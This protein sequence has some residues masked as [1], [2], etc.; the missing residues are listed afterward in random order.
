MSSSKSALKGLLVTA[1]LSTLTTATAI[2]A[3]LVRRKDFEPGD[4][5]NRTMCFCTNS[6]NFIQTNEDPFTLSHYTP[7][8]QVAFVYN[9]DY[10][11]HREIHVIQVNITPREH[12]LDHHFSL[13]V[14]DNCPTMPTYWPGHHSSRCLQHLAKPQHKTY[15]N[16]YY[17]GDLPYGITI[18]DWKFCYG[19]R[20]DVFGNPK[21]RDFFEF[22][23]DRRKLPR[24]R[25]WIA[26]NEEVAQV[27]GEV[28]KSAYGMEMFRDQ[29]GE[30]FSR[31]DYFH[32]SLLFSSDVRQV[33]GM[34]EL[35][36]GVMGGG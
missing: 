30:V 28:C 16:T 25:D 10:Y 7:H 4:T 14:Q 2:N 15:C 21:M 32:V 27:C 9:F 35:T 3:T 8:H 33:M 29:M 17:V 5:L 24:Q 20:G 26:D 34:S 13:T 1:L 36:L 23:K 22:Y 31:V 6:N 19:F 11:N 18:H 12:S